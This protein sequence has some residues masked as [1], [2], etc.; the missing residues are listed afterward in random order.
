MILIFF[1][2]SISTANGLKKIASVPFHVVGSF[3]VVEVNINTSTKLNL[4]LDSGVNTT[5]ITELDA[6]DSL[7]LNYI[8]K[9]KIKGLGPDEGIL[10]YTSYGNIFQAGKMKL[11]NQTVYLLE[12]DIFS[13]SKHVGTKINGILGANLFD[14]NIVKI[15]YN[16]QRITFYKNESFDAPKGFTGIPMILEGNKMFVT[17]PVTEADW[18]TRYSKMLLDTGA[19]LTAW[20]RSTGVHPIKLPEKKIRSYIGQGL[21]GEIEGYMGRI[22]MINLGGHVLNHPIVHFPDSAS[23]TGAILSSE[24]EGTIGSQILSRFNMIFDQKRNMLYVKPNW[25]FKKPFTYNIAG[26]EMIQE[27]PAIPFPEISHI[28][29]GSPADLAG[30]QIGDRI[31]QVNE[32]SVLNTNINVLRNYFEA[33][34]R[35]PLTILLMRGEKNLILKIEMKSVL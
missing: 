22:Y 3:I 16:N 13:L 32:A 15:D 10:A 27:D 28:R 17:I 35:N 1:P 12:E 7:T 33:S 26:I 29:E 21:N 31:I 30:V 19:E 6:E 9:T 5:I 18:S 23:I 14:G 2:T 8:G 24:R 25:K 34:S 11:I 20:F 4:I